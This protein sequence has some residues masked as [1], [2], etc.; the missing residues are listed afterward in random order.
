MEGLWEV[1]GIL[2]E[3]DIWVWM[4]HGNLEYS[5]RYALERSG[6]PVR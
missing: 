4:E 5:K 1:S 3:L 6:G 2:G